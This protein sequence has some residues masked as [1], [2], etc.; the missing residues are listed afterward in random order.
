MSESSSVMPDDVLREYLK[1]AQNGDEKAQE[2]IVNNNMAL[3]WSIVKRFLNRGYEAE[4]LVQIGCVGLIKA[5]K[6][7]DCSYNVK[8][9][10]YAVPIIMGEI[11]RFLRDDGMIKV[12]RSLKETSTKVKYVR[13]S[14]TK[15]L[16]REPT[17][18]EIA[19]ELKISVDDVIMAIDSSS[20][21][22][23]LYDYVNEDES[24]VLMDTLVSNDRVDESIVERIALK[25]VL[26]SLDEYEKNLIIMRYFQEKT[27]VE[28]AAALGIS[29]VQVSRLEKKILSKLRKELSANSDYFV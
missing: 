21:V 12:S 8:F 18:N 27:Q 13:D 25:D 24:K 20:S 15:K 29:Q 19:D 5:I 10:T 26:N 11:K 16:N 1:K 22:D 23:Y 2:V 7:F 9:S 17:V 6:K 4:D 28:I 14:L 3:V